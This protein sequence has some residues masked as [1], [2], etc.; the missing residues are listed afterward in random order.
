M[1][2]KLTLDG[3]P[4]DAKQAARSALFKVTMRHREFHEGQNEEKRKKKP[5]PFISPLDTEGKS[6]NLA[7]A[8]VAP[9]H[10]HGSDWREMLALTADYCGTSE[11]DVAFWGD[12]SVEGLKD[13][14]IM[15]LEA[16]S[17]DKERVLG[18]IV[19]PKQN[20]IEQT[21]QKRECIKFIPSGKDPLKCGCGRS[22]NGHQEY[23][24]KHVR[25]HQ[26]SNTDDEEEPKENTKTE[27]WSIRKHTV[28]YPTD[29][30]G[31]IE[32]QG[33]PHPYKAQY[34]RLG[35]DSDP[36]DIMQLFESCWQIQPPKLIITVHGGTT[37]FD[38]Q[39]K[40]A[41][42]FRKGLLKAARTTGAWIITSGVNAGVVRHVAAALDG[43]C[44]SA[45]ARCKVVS[46]GITPWGMLKNP[47]GF[48]G[49]DTAVDYH[50][51]SFSP[52]GKF[53]VLNNR[54][55]YYLLVDNG[56]V[57]R[58]F[59]IRSRCDPKEEA[60]ILHRAEAEV[61]RKGKP[62]CACSLCGK[63]E[64]LR[65]GLC[66]IMCRVFLES[67]SFAMEADAPRICSPSPINLSKRMALS[68][69]ASVRSC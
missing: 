36:A 53:A 19:I 49:T 25:K 13:I 41:R 42:V 35:F 26:T 30:H 60:G 24:E 18:S 3:Q 14:E 69:K 5:K 66:W 12:G 50:P 11:G 62:K 43:Q 46:I 9:Q 10:V 23:V 7:G 52:K 37:N 68:Q 31:T 64:R 16:L 17:S 44:S 48:V 32:F 22:K 63:E 58:L 51:H 15:C 28:A 45:R 8:K 20:W 55:S 2:Q 39:P 56:S 54:H 27:K 67:L 34:V 57:G 47:E 4:P 65:L 6:G 40:L 1:D 59:Q 29:A 33:G 61:G 38:I 21:F